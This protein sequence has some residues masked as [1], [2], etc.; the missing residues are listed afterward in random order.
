[1]SYKIALDGLDRDSATSLTEQIVSR[2][3]TAIDADELGPGEQLPTTRALAER[4]GVNHLTAVRAYR[5]FD[6]TAARAM[7]ERCLAGYDLPTEI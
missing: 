3:R 6:F 7:V 1:M 2:F 5:A 4:A